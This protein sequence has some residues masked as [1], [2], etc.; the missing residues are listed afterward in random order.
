MNKTNVVNM[1]EVVPSFLAELNKRTLNSKN[2]HILEIAKRRGY[3]TPTEIT[4]LLPAR[5]IK[6]REL[7]SFFVTQL[8]EYLKNAKLGVSGKAEVLEFPKKQVVSRPSA[9][10]LYPTNRVDE[11]LIEVEESATEDVSTLAEVDLSVEE[12]IEDIEDP[13]VTSKPLYELPW[14]D[15]DDLLYKYLQEAGQFRILSRD[16]EVALMQKIE[17]GDNVA[18]ERFIKANLRLV[19]SIARRYTRTAESLTILDLIQEGNIGLLKAVEKFDYHLGYKFSTYATWWIRQVITRAI[20]DTDRIVRIPVHLCETMRKYFKARREY[21][22]TLGREPTFREVTS[23]MELAPSEA[24]LLEEAL[25]F[26]NMVSLDE[27]VGDSDTPLLDLIADTSPTQ[28]DVLMERA[29]ADEVERAFRTLTQQ[30][31]EVLSLRTGVNGDR[32]FTLE[33]IGN[34][35]GFTREYARQ[36]AARAV[37]K[38]LRAIQLDREPAVVVEP[39]EEDPIVADV[40]S[41]VTLEKED[42]SQKVLQTVAKA[43]GVSVDDVLGV[44]RRRSFV[45]PRHLVMYLLNLDFNFSL[46]KLAKIFK[47]DHTSVLHACQRMKWIVERDKKLRATIANIRMDY[48]AS[49]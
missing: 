28:E 43:Y 23:A 19:V 27:E 5:V 14:A 45:W 42:A 6:D 31:R 22:S 37:K 38:V 49:P 44:S 40:G 2:S 33:D 32:S 15:H 34:K 17:K 41:V 4:E 29:N 39:P 16:E 35:F 1:G 12:A 21:T 20:M 7:L 3:I 26:Q 30:E 8:G 48:L 11:P 9:T 25:R 10:P 47:R 13:L 18:K 46:V 24:N 36:V